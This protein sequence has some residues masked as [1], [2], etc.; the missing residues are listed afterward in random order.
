VKNESIL[1]K[2]NQ[3]NSAEQL[4]RSI[5]RTS[6]GKC[7]NDSAVRCGVIVDTVHR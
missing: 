4:G 5:P 6:T 3:K 7:G 2:W 1:K